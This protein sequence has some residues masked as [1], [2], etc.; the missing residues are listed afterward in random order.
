MLHR[1]PVRPFLPFRILPPCLLPIRQ[2]SHLPLPLKHRFRIR[3]KAKKAGIIRPVYRVFGDN[4]AKNEEFY[5][6]RLK[7]RGRE[8]LCPSFAWVMV[9]DL[10]PLCK[11]SSFSGMFFK[12][13]HDRRSK[14]GKPRQTVNAFKG[15]LA[16]WVAAAACRLSRM[17]A[18][19]SGKYRLFCWGFLILGH[20]FAKRNALL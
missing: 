20:C 5:K 8:I 6:I 15:S 17:Y 14:A 13:W 2:K 11:N 1:E 12:N 3:M 19:L 9:S 18:L 10:I 4:H 7:K 16:F